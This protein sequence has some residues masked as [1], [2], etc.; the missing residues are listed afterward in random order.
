M[1]PEYYSKHDIDD[2]YDPK[3]LKVPEIRWDPWVGKH[4]EDT[5]ILILGHTTSTEGGEETEDWVKKL[6]DP[7]FRHIDRSWIDTHGI[8]R[9]K[10]P[11]LRTANIFLQ[12]I[13]KSVE[14]P[15]ARQLFW[16]SVAFSNYCQCPVA[17]WN[18]EC[19]CHDTSREALTRRI[20]ILEPRLCIAW[21]TELEKFGLENIQ[22]HSNKINGSYPR[23][24]ITSYGLI[25]GI[26]HPSMS[27][28]SSNWMDYFRD[29]SPPECKSAVSDF[30]EHLK[31]T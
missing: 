9:A 16:R 4:Y 3:F 28:T 19:G 18:S 14:D 5:K 11:F 2:T 27:F 1:G 21:T 13:G 31:V 12:E 17:K 26:R 15:K 6:K 22:K 29:D 23:F 8:K 10:K 25:V 24:A 7:D 20:E 30:L